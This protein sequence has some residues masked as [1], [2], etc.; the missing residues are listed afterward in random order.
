VNGVW[1]FCLT[2]PEI[3]GSKWA[4]FEPNDDLLWAQI[5]ASFAS[6]MTKLFRAGAF[7]GTKLGEAFSIRCDETT[8]TQDDI[9]SG[10]LN[11]IVG[12]AP[13]KPAEF[14]VIHI[15]QLAGHCT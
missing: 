11:I 2:Q 9:A 15:Q 6:F 7:Q 3:K 4:V 12:F 14:I 13:L 10:R 5:R 8:T 1:L